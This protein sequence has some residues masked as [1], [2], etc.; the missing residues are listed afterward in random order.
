MK[1]KILIFLAMFF[2]ANVPVQAGF[3]KQDPVVTA[4]CMDSDLFAYA[5]DYAKYRYKDGFVPVV[6]VMKLWYVDVDHKKSWVLKT[7]IGFKIK[8]AQLVQSMPTRLPPRIVAMTVRQACLDGDLEPTF[9]E[10]SKMSNAK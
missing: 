7:D 1:T 2:V 6:Y 10:V 5:T 9:K 3:F 8:M 4:M